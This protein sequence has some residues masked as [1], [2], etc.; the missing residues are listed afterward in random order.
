MNLRILKKLSKKAV[1]LLAHFN[2]F[3]KVFPAERGENYFSGHLITARKHWDRGR[4]VHGDIISQGEVKWPARDG[5]GWI[6]MRP[7]ACPLKGTP[8]V[9]AV[10]GYEEPEWDERTAWEEL[11]ECVAWHGKPATMT[12]EEWSAAQRLTRTSPVTDEELDAMAKDY[13]SDA[14]ACG[15]CGAPDVSG[16]ET[17][18]YCGAG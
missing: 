16:Y 4:S 6:Y 7:P 8:M 10:S 15:D 17:C 12:D 11:R 13:E 1:P 18:P 14:D 3:G 9:G 5:K 2:H